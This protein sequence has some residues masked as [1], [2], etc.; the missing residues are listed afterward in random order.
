MMPEKPVLVR[1]FSLCE[2][3]RH[4]EATGHECPIEAGNGADATNE[5]DEACTPPRGK[6][7]K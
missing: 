4:L 7:K 3:L 5:R 1:V 2:V 6:I